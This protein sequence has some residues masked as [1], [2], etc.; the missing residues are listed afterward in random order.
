VAES[1]IKL[2]VD[3]LPSAVWQWFYGCSSCSADAQHPGP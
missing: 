2:A 3:S 1:S